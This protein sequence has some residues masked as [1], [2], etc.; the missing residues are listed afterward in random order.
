MQIRHN[1]QIQGISNEIV[2]TE[3]ECKK[4]K[5]KN[6]TMGNI[7]FVGRFCVNLVD[8]QMFTSSTSGGPSTISG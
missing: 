8:V 7:T 4:I 5:L 2:P 1:K 6:C 3:N